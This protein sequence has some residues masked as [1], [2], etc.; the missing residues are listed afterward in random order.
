M[1]KRQSSYI[2]KPL[3]SKLAL[4]V[5]SVVLSFSISAETYSLLVARSDDMQ[6]AREQ[7]AIVSGI[8]KV[9]CRVVNLNGSFNLFCGKA[10]S[11]E[12]L[13][14]DL[15][16]LTEL[17]FDD[18]AVLTTHPENESIVEEF[19]P[20]VLSA[21]EQQHLIESAQ[22]SH[23]FQLNTGPSLGH[24]EKANRAKFDEEQQQQAKYFIDRGW[25]A[26]R[27][28]DY[29]FA[30]N[31]FELA[32]KVPTYAQQANHGLALTYYQQHQYQL[33]LSLLEPLISEEYQTVDLLMVAADAANQLGDTQKLAAFVAQLPE[34]KQSAWQQPATHGKFR[35]A[36]ARW[37]Q[38][39][40]NTNQ[41]I[42]IAHSNR[43][44]ADQCE[45]VETWL[46]IVYHLAKAKA[47]GVRKRVLERLWGAC[48]DQSVRLGLL[49]KR[50]PYLSEADF[51]AELLAELGNKPSASYRRA[52]EKMY[53]DDKL[54]KANQLTAA[55]AEQGDIYLALYEQWPEVKRVKMA[56]AWWS[57]NA[58]DYIASK[59]LF[60]QSWQSSNDPKALEGLFYSLV[61]LRDY[62][63]ALALARS[64]N[65][66]SLLLNMAKVQLGQASIPSAEASYWAETILTLDANYVPALSA[67]AWWH[68][69]QSSNDQSS[70]D[71][72]SIEQAKKYFEQWQALEP[73][74]PDAK[75]GLI[76][77][78]IDKKVDEPETEQQVL[79]RLASLAKQGQLPPE[80]QSYYAW[81]L[82]KAEQFE[83]ASEQF[84]QLYMQQPSVEAADGYLASLEKLNDE[85]R[86][87]LF[88]AQ[89]QDNKDP[90]LSAVV[91][92]N[93]YAKG[94]ALQAAYAGA[95]EDDAW[96]GANSPYLWLR[97]N[98]YHRKGERG[99][100]QFNREQTA[101]GL[102]W[103]FADAHK[104]SF[105]W[106]FEQLDVS[107]NLAANAVGRNYLLTQVLA[108]DSD[109]AVN[110]PWLEYQYLTENPLSIGIGFSPINAPVTDKLN[111][112]IEYLPGNWQLSFY[113]LPVTESQL[114]YA[115]WQDPYSGADWGGV[116]ELALQAGYEFKLDDSS[117][118]VSAKLA[119]FTGENI[120]DNYASQLKASWAFTD[121]LND[122]YMS[123]GIFAQLDGYQDNHNYYTFGHGGYFSPQQ[124]VLAGPFLSFQS[125][126][127]KDWWFVDVGLSLYDYQADGEDLYPVDPIDVYSDYV[128]D[129]GVGFSLRAEKHWLFDKQYE[130][131]LGLEV[132]DAPGY[133]EWQVGIMF[134]YFY[135]DHNLPIIRRKALRDRFTH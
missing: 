101:L 2:A 115:G 125:K 61:Q 65:E 25:A 55:S 106:N 71:P 52:L 116:Q 51:E 69:D 36:L 46:D 6:K 121:E 17:G 120:R 119:E 97:L 70:N 91:A 44:L 11:S 57:Y 10:E 76:L 20:V 82:F 64:S 60:E 35:A 12:R 129:S 47:F 93:L 15:Q 117:I 39:K 85:T 73:T 81:I 59:T 90:A 126:D 3:T 21:K 103:H 75:Q 80:Q 26:Y 62:Q 5:A 132:N 77:V 83:K 31:M 112:D 9:P 41:L 14:P 105:S 99:V 32:V 118:N 109:E 88:I 111:W 113:Q 94:L 58:G 89:L 100:N 72:K 135:D 54:E 84:Y 108:Q 8:V 114:S 104:L 110:W 42:D 74:N 30:K 4:T 107:G 40:T 28:Q 123:Y 92:A 19:E 122:V 56:L 63:G 43:H 130:L 98:Q 23:L 78:A 16:R 128:T 38:D 96:Y 67:L 53:I 27:A 66:Q 45:P 34:D 133:Q 86:K 18:I 48:S 37:H 124:M 95:Q 7:A 1:I 24:I 29:G 134:R 131:G 68:Y 49:Y 33:A 87:Q 50:K 102:S 22:S 79:N 127:Q 13:A